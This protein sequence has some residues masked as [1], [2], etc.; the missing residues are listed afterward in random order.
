[1]HIYMEY[2]NQL[3]L[4]GLSNSKIIGNGESATVIDDT[5]FCAPEILNQEPVK[6]G[7]DIW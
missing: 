2:N 6:P 4:I 3:K 7:T 5:E 1:M